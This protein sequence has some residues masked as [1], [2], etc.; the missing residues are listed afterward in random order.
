MLAAQKHARDVRNKL[1]NPPN[2][3]H[4]TELDIACSPA[5]R[6]ATVENSRRARLQ[7]LILDY[8]KIAARRKERLARSSIFERIIDAVCRHY[9]IVRR[10][11]MS[12]R[13]TPAHIRPRFAVYFLAFEMTGLTLAQIGRGVG[14]RDRTTAINGRDVVAAAL[15]AGD[16]QWSN[17]LNEIRRK[18]GPV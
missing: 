4:S 6:R 14:G 13:K 3:V 9:N 1:W 11:L 8:E 16:A 15:A 18:I 7:R 10:A 17:D 12:E 5:R 2:A